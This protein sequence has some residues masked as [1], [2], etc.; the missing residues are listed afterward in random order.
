MIQAADLDFDDDI[1][2]SSMSD[3]SL[4]DDKIQCYLCEV[5]GSRDD[6]NKSWWGKPLH[7]G[8]FNGV[9]AQW[10]VL[11]EAQ[12]SQQDAHKNNFQHNPP[13]WRSDIRDYMD[14]TKRKSAIAETR[15]KFQKAE[16]HA[17]LYGH[18]ELND[19]LLLNEEQYVCHQLQWTLEKDIAVH[20]RAWLALN[21]AQGDRWRK[22][23]VSRVLLSGIDKLRNYHGVA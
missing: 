8:C 23:G 4:P 20:R 2:A 3:V 6:V 17:L 13:K 9:R 10:R 22:G 1:G 14:P 19:D 7:N 12:P 21:Q 18:L 15:S 11:R 5:W 16:S